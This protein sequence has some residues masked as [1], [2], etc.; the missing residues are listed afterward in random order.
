[1]IL[2]DASGVVFR[3][4]DTETGK[5]VAL[6]RFFPFGAG[7]GG[8]LEDEQTA[9]N[10][11]LDRLAGLH[12]PALRSVIAGGCDPVDGI[13]FIATEWIEGEVLAP[14]IERR[15][16]PAE[17]AS[18]LL[19]Q[20][21]EV[22]ELL[23][24]VLA[25]E[26]VWVETDPQTIVL[27]NAES[28]RGFTFWISPLKWLGGNEQAGGM[29]SII[30]LAE[31]IMGWKGRMVS[32]QS[33]GGLGAWIKWL[34]Q[35]APTTTL[36]ELREN[37]AAAVGTEPPPAAAKLVAQAARP[38]ARKSS[39]VPVLAGLGLVLILTGLS[40]WLHTRNRPIPEMPEAAPF[41]SEASTVNQRAAEL[42]AQATA[43]DQEK[44]ATLAAQHS[45]V[46]SRGGV[47]SPA[48]GDWLALQKGQ[49]ARLEGRL[50]KTGLSNSGKT[51]YLY[52]SENPTATEPRGAVPL[53]AA[54]ADL[55]ETSLAAFIGKKIRI[56]GQVALQNGRPEIV[57]TTRAAIE[58][59]E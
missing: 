24:H 26:G 48:E 4:L 35:A 10:I 47:F 12:H 5:S 53:K 27:G 57:I 56:S 46:E 59:A 21:L 3:A 19:T 40:G 18:E 20:A 23:S 1:M 28:G 9:Y 30:L 41:S 51:L 13:P 17:A 8:L 38:P 58:A 37:L 36:R 44:Q 54:P 33:G 50:A 11:A 7:G 34:R 15:P 39:K 29:A 14:L 55:S 32:D 42:S 31:E 43:A 25:E 52:F 22:S 6:R 2:Q 49:P 45:A 16:L